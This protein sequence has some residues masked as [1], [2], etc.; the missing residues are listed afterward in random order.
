MDCRE[1][2]SLRRGRL[3]VL[4][5]SPAYW[6]SVRP[7]GAGVETSA[8]DC[9]ESLTLWWGGL[10]VIVTSP[11]YRGSVH[12]QGTC[13]GATAGYV[14]EF[15]SFGRNVFSVERFWFVVLDLEPPA[16]WGSVL[17]DA[18]D[19]AVAAADF[20]QLGVSSAEDEPEGAGDQNDQQGW[21]DFSGD[22][23]AD[24]SRR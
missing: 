4:V 7:Q 19:V 12:F 16:Y 14:G 20:H 6:S 10:S 13:V 15:L 2:L 24:I 21:D 18:A 8:A 9:C 17:F 11:A 3:P 1:S 23:S 5:P 22:S